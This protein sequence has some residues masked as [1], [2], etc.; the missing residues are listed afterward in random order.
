MD[1]RGNQVS[2]LEDLELH[3]GDPD[4][5]MEAVFRLRI[6]TLFSPSTFSDF[7]M[8]S[9][10]ENPFLTDE[11][12]DKENSPSTS[13]GCQRPTQ[14]PALMRTLPLQQELRV[15]PI[16]GIEFCSNNIYYRYC[17]CISI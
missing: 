1:S 15:F 17:V 9:K 7:Q 13:P 5:N 11:G 14:P 16:M 4:L 2:N 3:W 10:A 12:E 6:V 8:S